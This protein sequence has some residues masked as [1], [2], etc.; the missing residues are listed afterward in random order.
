M[1]EQRDLYDVLGVSRES[2]QDQ[3]KSAFRK[4]A[5]EFHPDLNQ[6]PEAERRF[7]EI[8]LAYETL[9]DPEKRRRYDM[10]GGEGF[11]P[12]MFNFGDLSGI[13]EAFFGGGSPFG[14]PATRRRSR[15]ARGND[16][17][18][19]LELTFEE[20][21]FG[22][23]REIAVDR[24]ERCEQCGGSG[25]EPGTQPTRCSTCGG[26]GQVSDVRQSVFG[27]VMTSRACGTCQGTGEEIASPCPECRGGGRLAKE[28][29]M[30]VDVPA[31]V[32]HGMELRVEGAG[33]DGRAGGST[34]DLYLALAVEPHPVFERRGQDLLSALELPVSAAILGAE[35]E[36]ET[37]DGP[38]TLSVPAG[39]QPGSV[40]KLSGKGVPNLGR[41]GRGDLLV[42][43][44]VTLPDRL[45]RRE[46]PLIEEFAERRGEH[47]RPM[48]GR[49]RPI[50]P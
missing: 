21:V 32:T 8:N 40:I 30:T 36:V 45:G 37:L 18:L 5:R 42:R 39:T 19:I 29:V 33:D 46:R 27:T 16:Q 26:S 23:Q 4:L 1:A 3:I 41:R 25:A 2:T 50:Q 22:A 15:S 13:F 17:R 49:L 10:F 24:M 11:T 6:D 44:D 38:A 28:Q 35:V 48:R 7:K 34:G 9:S 47:E 12:D 43:V 31:G 20:S 14:R